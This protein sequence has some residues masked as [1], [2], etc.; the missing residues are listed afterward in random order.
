M[1]AREEP[2]SDDEVEVVEEWTLPAQPPTGS[3]SAATDPCSPSHIPVIQ[4]PSDHTA[5]TTNGD[6]DTGKREAS[7]HVFECW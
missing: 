6:K 2:P 7:S 5:L 1:S 3:S 4:R